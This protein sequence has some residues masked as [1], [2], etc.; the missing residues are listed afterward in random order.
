MKAH[1]NDVTCSHVCLT[2][3]NHENTV[4]K[5]LNALFSAAVQDIQE[6]GI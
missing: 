1:L 4:T 2:L 5:F 6:K 3:R